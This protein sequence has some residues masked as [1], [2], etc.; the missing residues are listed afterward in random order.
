MINISLS[1]LRWTSKLFKPGFH[2]I[3]RIVPVVSKHVQTIGTIIWKPG[4]MLHKTRWPFVFAPKKT[5]VQD[6]K[7]SLHSQTTPNFS[8]ACLW[9]GRTVVRCTV[10]WL[11]NFL[12]WVDLLT[13]GAP[14]VRA[15]PRELRYKRSTKDTKTFS[16]RHNYMRMIPLSVLMLIIDQQLEP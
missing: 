1:W 9:C 3:V 2:M 15:S 16:S 13:H 11:P 10:T 6:P 12:G 14:L 7:L 5:R 4:F 8:L